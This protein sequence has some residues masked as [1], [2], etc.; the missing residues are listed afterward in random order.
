[1]ANNTPKYSNKIRENLKNIPDDLFDDPNR[2][3][4]VDLVKRQYNKDP[5]RMMLL[6]KRMINE[7]K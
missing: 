1:M 6:I 3:I 5:L 2:D 4:K 7:N